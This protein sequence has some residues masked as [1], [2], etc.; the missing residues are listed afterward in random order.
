MKLGR[1]PAARVL[2]LGLLVL[3]R[4]SEADELDQSNFAGPNS[5]TA[6]SLDCGTIALYQFARLEGLHP[7][8]SDVRAHLPPRNPTGYSMLELQTAAGRLGM[9][10]R[11]VRLRK[12]DRAP[13]SAAIVFLAQPGNHGHYVVI[14]PIG[15]SGKLVQVLDSIGSPIL[16]DV[17]QMYEAR[18]W[19]GLALV[20][21]RTNWF[22]LIPVGISAIL[23]GAFVFPSLARYRERRRVRVPS[24]P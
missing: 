6:Q 12:S 23:A 24:Y 4:G 7:D 21:E 13:T 19:T 15:H 1:S 16:L 18:Q 3:I 2:G 5:S 9:K 17:A 20:P 10:L 8:L 11:G 14:R 22:L